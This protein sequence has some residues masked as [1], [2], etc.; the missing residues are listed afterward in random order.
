VRLALR[1]VGR[2]KKLEENQ[3]VCVKLAPRRSTAT[4]S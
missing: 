2:L 1:K 3:Q 4:R